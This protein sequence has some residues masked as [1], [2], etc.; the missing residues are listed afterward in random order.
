MKLLKI[1]TDTG[2]IEYLALDKILS[3]KPHGGKVKI[4]M[5]AGLYWWAERETMEILSLPENFD[6]IIEIEFDTRG[7]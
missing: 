5:G 2:E 6:E 1:V 3:I 4:L 7:L